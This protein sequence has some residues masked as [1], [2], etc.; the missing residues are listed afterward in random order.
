MVA[1]GSSGTWSSGILDLPRAGRNV[2]DE[3][4]LRAPSGM[5]W[6]GYSVRC[7]GYRGRNECRGSRSSASRLS[8]HPAGMLRFPSCA[9]AGRWSPSEPARRS[10]FQDLPQQLRRTGCRWRRKEN[11]RNSRT[12]VPLEVAVLK[13]AAQLSP[14]FRLCLPRANRNQVGVVVNVFPERL[15]I[16]IVM[17]RTPACHR[18]SR[19]LGH[20]GK[21][22]RRLRSRFRHSPHEIR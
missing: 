20:T 22:T 4:L 16:A 14:A 15:G 10:G 5:W 13:V 6:P 12:R 21:M 2:V 9:N 7:A 1:S 19:W 3:I 8:N 17:S 18:Q 11:R